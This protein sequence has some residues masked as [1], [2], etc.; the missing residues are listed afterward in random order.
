MYQV[1]ENI[2]YVT[3]LNGYYKYEGMDMAP[4]ETRLQKVAADADGLIPFER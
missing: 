3:Y 1:N 4:F 2:W